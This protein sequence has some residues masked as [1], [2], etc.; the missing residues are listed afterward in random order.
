LRLGTF[1]VNGQIPSQD[2]SSWV[3][4][5]LNQ[6]STLKEPDFESKA[7][8][9]TPLSPLQRISP[10]S[11]PKNPFNW[12]V[13]SFAFYGGLNWRLFLSHDQLPAG[14]SQA[15]DPRKTLHLLTNCQ[16]GWM[17]WIRTVQ[18][19]LFSGSK[20]STSPQKPYFIR[21]VMQGRTLGVMLSLPP[22]GRRA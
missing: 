21:Q 13:S 10:F 3:Q 12:G 11:I 7:E 19:C 1:N 16:S 4:G 5:N 17:S 22:L 9:S 2:L 18:I 8:S 20:N 6:N 14:L 15:M